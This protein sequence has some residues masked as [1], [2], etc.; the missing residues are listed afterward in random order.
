MM[1]TVSVSMLI[2]FV[3][4]FW[5]YLIWVSQPEW[6]ATLALGGMLHSWAILFHIPASR[7]RL[8]SKL[9]PI[10]PPL[11]VLDQADADWGIPAQW[12]P[13]QRLSA[14]TIMLVFEKIN[15]QFQKVVSHECNFCHS[16][17]S[18]HHVKAPVR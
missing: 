13:R 1:K 17:F 4:D 6:P 8:G 7:H 18:V 16:R 10:K 3:L 5:W 12:K 15:S 2:K 11:T 14:K 9:G